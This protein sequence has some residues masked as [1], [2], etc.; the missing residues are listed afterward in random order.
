MGLR[1]C[2]FKYHYC[3]GL[4]IF[5]KIEL[6][7]LI[8]YFQCSL[9]KKTD[10]KRWFTPLVCWLIVG[11]FKYCI[12]DNVQSTKL[13]CL[14]QFFLNHKFLYIQDSC[15]LTRMTKTIVI[16]THW[17]SS[18][19]L[20]PYLSKAVKIGGCTSVTRVTARLCT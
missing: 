2:K 11:S 1:L 17:A 7:L 10:V 12:L 18:R 9:D 13:I 20:S 16:L 5:Q 14:L 15:H 19:N 4:Q 8:A 3:E 6:V